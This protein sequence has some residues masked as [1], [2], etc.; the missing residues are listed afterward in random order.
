[1]PNHQEQPLWREHL[2]ETGK[3]IALM[4]FTGIIGVGAYVWN[5][6]VE[7]TERRIADQQATIYQLSDRL[8][9]AELTAATNQQL[10]VG[11]SQRLDRLEEINYG[12]RRPNG[13][14]R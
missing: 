5:T 10:V 12:F 9:V 11:I 14:T 13:T 2:F 4:L 8:R 3:T 7:R 6:T 1:M